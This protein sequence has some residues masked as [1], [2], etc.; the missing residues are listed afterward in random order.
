M[1]T[2]STPGATV[3][4]PLGSERGDRVETYEQ[5]TVSWTPPAAARATT[6]TVVTDEG[7]S[8]AMTVAVAAPH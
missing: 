7:E 4:D 6:V 3:R 8:A 5:R 1:T 2:S